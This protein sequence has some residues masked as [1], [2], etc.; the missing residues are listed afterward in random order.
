MAYTIT[1]F[2]TAKAVRDAFKA[3][4]EIRVYQPGPF[5]PKVKDGPTCLE[6]P[7]Y[8]EAH[9]WY[10]GVEVKSGVVTKVKR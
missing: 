1:N 4:A 2:R 7:H 5:G 3:G 8:P 9:T 6:G 10:L